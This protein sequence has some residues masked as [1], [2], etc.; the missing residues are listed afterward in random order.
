MHFQSGDSCDIVADMGDTLKGHEGQKIRALLKQADLKPADLARACEVTQTSVSRY[1]KP[2]KLGAKAWETA[3]RGLLVL[4]LDPR[5]IRPTALVGMRAME[6]PEDLRPL[7][8][9]FSRKHLE[10]LKLILEASP[11]AQFILKVVVLDRLEREE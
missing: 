3:S 1:L 7:I 10:A 8:H 6:G 2:E 9:G 11:D 5:Q 4:G